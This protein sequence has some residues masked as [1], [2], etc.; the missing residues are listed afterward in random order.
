MKDLSRGYNWAWFLLSFVIPIAGIVLQIIW[1]PERRGNAK[2][3]MWGWITSVSI[4][5]VIP[6][7][8]SLVMGIFA[9]TGL[10]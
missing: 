9:S 8:F 2:A 6:L 3:C 1:W 4:F 7:L 5:F 10:I